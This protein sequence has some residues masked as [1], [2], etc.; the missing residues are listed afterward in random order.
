MYRKHNAALTPDGCSMIAAPDQSNI[1]LA[2]V[3][4]PAGSGR[5][6]CVAVFTSRR[7]SPKLLDY[8]SCP[9]LGCGSGVEIKDDRGSPARQYALLPASRSKQIKVS[10]PKRL[11]IESRLKYGLDVPQRQPY[12]IQVYVDGVLHRILTFTTQPN[13]DHRVFVDGCERLVGRREFAY[14]DIDCGDKVVEIKSTHDAYVNIHS[15]GLELCRPDLNRIFAV[16]NWKNIQSGL[17]LWDA[18]ESRSMASIAEESFLDHSPGQ[19]NEPDSLPEI[20]SASDLPLTG[21]METGPTMQG[22]PI[23]DPYQNQQRIA[24]L[25]R[26][27]RMEHGGLRAYM[28][29]RAI[30]VRHYG[31]ADFG[32]E[33][34][35][36]QL[37]SRMREHTVFKDLLPHQ[38]DSHADLRTI[39]FAN[40]SIRRP[41]Q[42]TTEVIV[43][44]QHL[45]AAVAGIPSATVS[46]LDQGEQQ[47]IRYEVP[48]SLG[49]S[50][51]RVLVDQ[52]H[53]RNNACLMVQ[54]D[55]SAPVQLAVNP[56][57]PLKSICYTPGSAAA[58]LSSLSAIPS[59]LRQR[60]CGWPVCDV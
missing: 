39:A 27:N 16:P 18:S 9:I 49:T 2:K 48:E 10:G 58:A 31:D 56:G 36:P 26:N 4:N 14:L 57:E 12:W 60:H 5:P 20:Q 59:S 38:L 8:Y 54:F 17:S 43:G 6:V 23:W 1:S 44:E 52:T 25:A 53:L 3:C 40:L 37:A 28:W 32:D 29:M 45:P 11:R 24:H 22:D 46:R 34:S 13:R 47:A 30:A 55:D 15:V 41:D 51:V 21:L 19:W 33:I 50:I 7:V 42:Q 35:V